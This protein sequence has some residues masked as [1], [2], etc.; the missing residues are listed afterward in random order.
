MKV[1]LTGGLGYIGSHTA[2]EALNAGYEVIIVD[3]LSN[4]KLDVVDKIK[5]ITGKDFIFYQADVCDKEAM[6]KIFEENSNIFAVIHFA[7]YKCVNDSIYSPLKYYENNLDST[8]S[9]LICMQKYDCKNFIFSSSAALYSND[10]EMPVDENGKIEPI[11]PYA[12]TKH[13]N[14]IVLRDFQTANPDFDV[15]VLR[16][17]NPVGAHISGLIGENPNDLPT[18]I[19]PC[20]CRAA[21]GE[22][23]KF[24]IFGNDYDTKDGTCIRDYIHVVDLAIGHIKALDRICKKFG[25]GFRVYNLGTGVGYSVLEMVNTFNKVNGNLVKFEFAPRRKGDIVVSFASAEKAE[26]E[27]GFKA[28]RTLEEMCRSSYLFKINNSSNNN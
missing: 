13:M 18:N 10:N 28:T 12:R 17:F 1:L 25:D 24:Q 7:G 14:E 23:D 9:I 22:A 26:K 3:N 15:T 2:V 20:I 27:L 8:F 19:M 11:C 4:S 21:V 6:D 16:Y 5:T